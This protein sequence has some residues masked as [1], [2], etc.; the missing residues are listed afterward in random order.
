MGI[1][2]P[3]VDAEMSVIKVYLIEDSPIIRANLIAAL[4]EMAPVQVVGWAE[5]AKDAIA[6][7]QQ[8]G[9]CQLVIVDIFLRQGSGLEVLQALTTQAAPPLALV[10]TNYATPSV[11]Q[12]CQALGAVQVLDKSSELDTLFDYC[13]QLAAEL[14]ESGRA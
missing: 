2:Q 4:E 5:Q 7:L 9:D 13:Q 3:L 14:T 6:W 11:R 1:N 8:G 12:Q 10:L